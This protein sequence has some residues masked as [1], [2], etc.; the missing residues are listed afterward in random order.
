MQ[1][2]NR[3]LRQRTLDYA[4]RR[5]DEYLVSKDMYM[6]IH[7]ARIK[8]IRDEEFERSMYEDSWRY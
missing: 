6:Q 5:E 3:R 2:K 8:A 7:K 1:E 4:H